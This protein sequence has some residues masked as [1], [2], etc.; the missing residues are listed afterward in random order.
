MAERPSRV[1]LV[2]S[3]GGSRGAYEVGILEFLRRDLSKRLG[4]PVPFDIISGTSVGALNAAYLAAMCDDPERQITGLVDAWRSLRIEQMLGLGAV[5]ILRAMRSLLRSS[6]PPPKPGTFRY[7]GILDTTGLER[8]VIHNIPWRKIRRNLSRGIMHAL[9]VSTTHV[10]TGHT[11]VFVNSGAP[12]PT[13][14]SSNP[15]VRHEEA[16][17]GPRHVLASA[18]IPLLFPAVSIGGQFYSDGGLRQNTPMSPAIRMGADHLL[19]ISLRH[20]EDENERLEH[21]KER[22]AAYPRPLFLMGKALNALLLDPTDYDLERMRRLNAVLEAG[23]ECFGAD[24]TDTINRKFVEMRGAPLRR[25]AAVHLRPSHDIGRL[26]SDFVT[27]GRA[28][29]HSRVAR[30]LLSRLAELESSTEND[31]LSYFLFDGAYASELIELGYRDAAAKED[32]LAEFFLD[33]L[34]ER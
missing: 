3:G 25:L 7:G 2:L 17:I 34:A 31:L 4:R 6:P 23:E 18:A 30:N 15:F 1:G 13:A 11:V 33:V 10:G 9:T 19:L 29:V 8:F 24:F 26:A 27:R 5:D 32:E 21:A 14:W 16:A 20:Q 12:I 28:T 22:E